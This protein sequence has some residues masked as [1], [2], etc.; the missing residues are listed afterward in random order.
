MNLQNTNLDDTESIAHFN[1]TY[2]KWKE[3]SYVWFYSPPH[4]FQVSFQEQKY[5]PL[6]RSFWEG[7]AIHLKGENAAKLYKV[8]QA[9]KFDWT[10]LESKNQ[11]VTLGRF[12]LYYFR[13]SKDM[14]QNEQIEHFMEKSCQRIKSKSKRRFAQWNRGPDGLCMKIGKRGSGNHYRVYEK[15][16]GLQFEIETKKTVANSFQ[17]LLFHNSPNDSK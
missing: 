9:K 1:S 15:N 10:I 17:K 16:N 3:K 13:K 7:T 12:D 11:N 6:Y 8:I 5:D 4:K 2:L 14:D